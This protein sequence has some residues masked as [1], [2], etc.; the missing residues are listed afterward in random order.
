MI[1]REFN[2]E[3]KRKHH[4]KGRENTMTIIEYNTR[5]NDLRLP[6]I[7]E[8]RT[9]YKIDGRRQYCDPAA[10]ADL[11]GDV[12]GLRQ[13]AEE[14][15]YIAAF[16]SKLRII[17]VFE[18][19]HGTINTSIID[20]RGIYQKSLMLGA[21]FVAV[22]HNHPTGDCTPSKDDIAIT[23]TLKKAG[24]IIGVKLIDHLI[25]GS[26]FFSF[27]NSGNF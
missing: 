4:R 10:L 13:A 18:A 9:K 7:A 2:P 1:R 20:V 22:A 25:I 16:D 12:I 17:G 5:L 8:T 14:Y 19:G 23:G 15:V 11:F 6:I 26:G 27:R 21:A 24:D 3:G